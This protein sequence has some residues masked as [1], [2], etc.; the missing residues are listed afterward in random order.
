MPSSMGVLHHLADPR[1][2]L[3]ALLAVLKPR[4][5]L[6]LG[7]YSATARRDITALREQIATANIEPTP[8][9]ARVSLGVLHS[10][11]EPRSRFVASVPDFYNLHE[12]RD[13]LFHV[14]EHVFTLPALE[15]LL[16]EV[17]GAAPL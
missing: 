10:Q 9:A 15:K 14:Q 12:C 4:G 8:R 17:G 7:L 11:H 3:R 6:R 2:G 1:R 16:N 5:W 13:L